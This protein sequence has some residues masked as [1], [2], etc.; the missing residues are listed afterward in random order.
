MRESTVE[1]HLHREVERAGGTTRKFKS[2][3][4]PNVPD[5]IVIWPPTAYTA[6]LPQVHFIETKAPGKK[7][8]PAQQREFA[9][10][11]AFGCTVLVL[12]TKEAVDNYVKGQR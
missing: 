8:R 2:P 10:L 11:E 9:R 1:K 5:R 4:R 3:G 7:P 6:L 12:D